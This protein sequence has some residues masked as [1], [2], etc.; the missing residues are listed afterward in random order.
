MAEDWPHRNGCA[1]RSPGRWRLTHAAGGA[2]PGSP[3][4]TYT[5]GV[6]QCS[7]PSPPDRERHPRPQVRRRTEPS[8]LGALR[9]Q[10]SLAGGAGDGPQ[11][12]SLDG[13]HRSGRAGGD[14][15]DPPTTVLLPRRTAHPLGA[16]PHF[17][18]ATALAL[19]K[20][21]Q[22]RP[23]TIARPAISNLTAPVCH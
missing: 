1:E 22:S 11:P 23:G 2:T 19:G 8:P 5:I 18:S 17:A 15:Q 21:V 10:R 9:R 7:R 4:R 13:A 12:G 6:D 16:P 20:P 3:V 14:H